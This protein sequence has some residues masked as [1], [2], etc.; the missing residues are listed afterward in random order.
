MTAHRLRSLHANPAR[1]RPRPVAV[2][3]QRIESV[4]LDRLARLVPLYGGMKP[5]T[6]TPKE[7]PK[8]TRCLF[9]HST[10]SP[11]A[12]E[13]RHYLHTSF[14]SYR[15]CAPCAGRFASDRAA[16]QAAPAVEAAA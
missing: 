10:L 9:C 4:A 5:K 8:M 16:E 13:R 2:E 7:G 15:L 12:P 3:A 14:G 1:F 6:S 11:E